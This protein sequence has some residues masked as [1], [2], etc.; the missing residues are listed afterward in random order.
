MII[1]NGLIYK[2]EGCFEKGTVH[3]DECGRISDITYGNSNITA[4]DAVIDAEGMYVIPGLIDIHFHGCYGNDLCDAD[5]DGLREMLMYELKSGIT[6]VCPA[7]M[8]YNEEKLTE[9]FA[10]VKNFIENNSDKDCATIHG[11]NMEG[12][13]IS[14]NKKAAQNGKFICDPDID[15]FDRV[16]K[17]SGDN[18]KLVTV[19]PEISGALDFIKEAS[20][21]AH[22]SL[23]HTC[24]TYEEAMSGFKAGASHVTHF[25]NGMSSFEHRHPGLIGAAS[26]NDSC[27]VE[28]IADGIHTSYSA[29]R[30]AMKLI[31]G[32]R[33]VLI[34]DSMRACGMP[35]GLYELGGQRVIKEGNRAT[36]EDGVIAGSVCNLMDC[37]R[38][39]VHNVGIPFSTAIKCATVNPA[40]AIDIFDNYG[41]IDVGKKADI[42]IVDDSLNIT[43]IIKG[44]RII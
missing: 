26:D 31:G 27:F 13:F 22:V 38:N 42:V 12:P 20:K 2:T 43:N 3:I 30:M 15:M 4:D 39:I 16:R 11:I 32:E 19:A 6:S 21:Y 9:I 41:S 8:T 1:I 40:K 44:G 36:L 34:S 24:A 14:H 28:L 7:S 33:L 5:E 35:D 17:A 37:V 25:Y 18:I 10:E 29:I 23:G